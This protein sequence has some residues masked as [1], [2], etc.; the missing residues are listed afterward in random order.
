[1][2]DLEGQSLEMPEKIKPSEVIFSKGLYLA[3]A[4]GETRTPT[5]EPR[6]DPE[7][8]ASTNSATSAKTKRN[9]SDFKF[10]VNRFFDTSVPD[11]IFTEPVEKYLFSVQPI[12]VIPVPQE[13]L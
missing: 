4:E 1:M 2:S 5:G 11:N 13:V 3:G 6:L 8:S 10:T 12:P 9:I 7:P